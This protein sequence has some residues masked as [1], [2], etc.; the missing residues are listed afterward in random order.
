MVLRCSNP[1]TA[2]GRGNANVGGS[3][4]TQGSQQ[5]IIRGVG[6]LR[7][8]DDI[9]NI[10]ITSRGGDTD[11]DQGTL[12]TLRLGHLPMEG[13]IG[14]DDTDDIVSGIVLM[15]KGENPSDVLRR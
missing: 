3:K 11:F 2:L 6:L 4:V 14:Q 12:R 13:I 9:S 7:S 10:V 5:Y 1:I 15:R 8:P